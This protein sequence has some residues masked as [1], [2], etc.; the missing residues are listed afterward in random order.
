MLPISISILF[1]YYEKKIYIEASQVKD[2]TEENSKVSPTIKMEIQEWT[3]HTVL[4]SWDIL[5]FACKVVINFFFN[6]L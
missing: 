2:G 6:D 4:S 3:I 1:F 5:F